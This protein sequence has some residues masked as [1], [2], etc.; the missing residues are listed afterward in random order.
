MTGQHAVEEI[1]DNTGIGDSIYDLV[2]QYGFVADRQAWTVESLPE[3]KGRGESLPNINICLDT[4]TAALRGKDGDHPEHFH[5][6]VGELELVK[7]VNSP[8]TASAAE[9]GALCKSESEKLRCQLMAF[10]ARRSDL[11]GGEGTPQ[12]KLTAYLDVE[13]VQAR[14]LWEV[15]RPGRIANITYFVYDRMTK[16][17][18]ERV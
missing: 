6:Q 12:G 13:K 18:L 16:E 9:H 7:T 14:R 17:Q 10:K 4:V 15:N 2:Y 3:T 1:I 8:P 11:F 5:H